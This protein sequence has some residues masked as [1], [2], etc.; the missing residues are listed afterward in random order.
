MQR[1]SESITERVPWVERDRRRPEGRLALRLPQ[2]A[3]GLTMRMLIAGTTLALMAALGASAAELPVATP[4]SLGFDSGRTYRFPK[5]PYGVTSFMAEFPTGAEA[6]L[7][8][9]VGGEAIPR[10]IGLDGV[11]RWSTGAHGIR[12]GDM[13]QWRGTTR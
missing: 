8:L 11:Y 1:R 4:A 12:I 7:T 6:A 3:R 2:A 5:N 9:A 13:A 10:P